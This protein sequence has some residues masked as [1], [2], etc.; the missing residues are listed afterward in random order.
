MGSVDILYTAGLFT[1]G[2]P[3]RPDTV[4]CAAGSNASLKVCKPNTFNTSLRDFPSPVH[5]SPDPKHFHQSLV[6]LPSQKHSRAAKSRN[7]E[8]SV[9]GC[10]DGELLKN[11]NVIIYLQLLFKNFT[12]KTVW[13][14][15]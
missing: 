8:Q 7:L 9:Q 12:P 15:P 10:A 5:H 14:L 2:L 11:G 4:C 1:S 6:V 13:K 3:V